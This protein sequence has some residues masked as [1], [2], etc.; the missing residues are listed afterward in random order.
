MAK[1]LVVEDESIVAWDIKET[2]EKLGHTVV[3]L[4]I[5]GAEAIRSATTDRPDLVLMDIR[6][7]GELDGIAAGDEIYHRLN[8][9][10]VYLTAHAD[11]ITLARATKTDPFGYIIK[12]FQPQTLQSTIQVACQRHQL[13][14]STQLT[15]ASLT[16]TLNSIGSGIIIVDRQGLVT[17]I[18]PIAAVLTG[19]NAVDAIGVE[20]DRI[21]CLIWELDG[22][23]IENPCSRAMRL[24]ET[25]RSFDRCWLVS[26]DKS[27]IPISDTATPIFRPDG[28]IFGSIII[29]HDNTQQLSA[30]LDL[31][32][33]NQ[34]LELFQLNLISKF[35][36]QTVEYQQAIACLQVLDLVLKQVHTTQSETEILQLAIHQFGIAIDADY[37]WFT[38][39]DPQNATATI[40][41]EYVSKKRQINPTSKIGKEIDVLLYLEFYN[42]LFESKSWIDPSP[43]IS[44]KPYLDL[45]PLAAQTIVCPIISDL[46]ST[47]LNQRNN[48][49]IG[50]V[51]ILT[52]PKRQWKSAQAYLFTQIL[53]CTIQL[54]RHIH[55]S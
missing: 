21:Y 30:Q 10:V 33:R 36:A 55:T 1:I 25:V 31:C 4:A 32:D 29:F 28:E 39:H 3:D 54:F 22:T 7:E 44:P 9:P 6:L 14:A 17:F 52:T 18:N 26:K 13:E 37:C 53:H 40:V 34:D 24:K 20:I 16:D 8:I 47:K 42:Q 23:A 38:L 15:Q 11:E 35:Q 48:G 50:E 41:G 5:S 2:L 51:G 27:E 45:F 12:P 46:P 43:K 49:T 19:W